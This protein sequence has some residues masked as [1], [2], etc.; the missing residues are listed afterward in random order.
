MESYRHYV[1]GFFA[2]REE[3]EKVVSQ[4]LLAGL[5]LGRVHL[6]DKETVLP[7]TDD[8]DRNQTMLKDILVDG[9]IGTAVGTGL[10]ALVGVGLIA[11]NVTL[12][13]AS[14]LVAPLVLLG[15]GA[16]IGGLIGAGAGAAAKIKPLS[17]LV[18]D[19]IM[20]GQLVVVV[21]TLSPEETEKAAGIIKAAVGDYHD[22]A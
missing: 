22:M 3:T 13:I 6:F 10:S 1:S 9:A 17:E 21:E 8:K 18:Y 19:A 12:F 20:S 15:W 14:P 16:G 5:P 7:P 2:H 11:A 4:L